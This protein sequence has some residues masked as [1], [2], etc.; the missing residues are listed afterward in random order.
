M[1]IRSPAVSSMSISRS[2]G[3]AET[4]W[5]R[6]SSSSVVRPIAETTTTTSWPGMSGLD[7]VVGDGLDAIGIGHGG[8]AVLLHD[9][10]H[11]VRWYRRSPPRP[12]SIRRTP[13]GS[14]AVSKQSKRDRQRQNREARREYETQ[15]ERRRKTW[16]TVR[17]FAI[18]AVPILVIGII[19]SVTSGGDD[20]QH[21]LGDRRARRS[22]R[23]R[24]RRRRSPRRRR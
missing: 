22:R 6:R 14:P 15:L 16:K 24:R 19:V 1:E 5:A 9:E 21:G 8:A 7:D 13:L 12:R 2:A 18:I 11:D 20:E 4:S 23:R 17:T 3:A 10:A